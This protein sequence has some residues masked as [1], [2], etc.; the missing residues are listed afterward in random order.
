MV[1]WI[2]YAT[3][4]ISVIIKIHDVNQ[5]VQN[6][7]GIRTRATQIYLMYLSP[8]IVKPEN[9][10]NTKRALKLINFFIV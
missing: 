3:A 2:K 1:P 4:E 9:A 10:P 5:S 8:E 6:Y 7:Q